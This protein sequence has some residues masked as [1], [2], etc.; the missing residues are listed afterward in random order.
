[1][2]MVLTSLV[3]MMLLTSWVVMVMVLTS[4]VMV[5]M[6][7][8]TSLVMVMV[9]VLTSLVMV[10]VMMLTS[11]VMVMVMV[12][13]MVVLSVADW[14][15]VCLVFRKL[16]Q[17]RIP[18]CTACPICSTRSFVVCEIG[19]FPVFQLYLFAS[20]LLAKLIVHMQNYHNNYHL[21]METVVNTSSI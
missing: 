19:I 3:M 8:L 4:L 10:M 16:P 12:M 20:A 5:M 13:V 7:V 6:M 14:R 15:V 21:L 11:L 1:M 17:L 2:V 18:H 9:M